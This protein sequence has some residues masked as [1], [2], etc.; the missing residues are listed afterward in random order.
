MRGKGQMSVLTH[1]KLIKIG[2]AWLFRNHPI[3]IT[4][5]GTMGEE[6]DVIGFRSGDST[7]I[8]CKASRADYYADKEK[9]FRKYPK[10]GMGEHRYF[11][12]PVGLI[13]HLVLPDGWGLLETDGRRVYK[14]KQANAQSANERQEKVILLSALRRIARGVDRSCSINAYVYNTQNRATLTI[15]IDDDTIELTGEESE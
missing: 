2:R 10:S 3:V 1:Q 9:W 8:E 14:R 7:L 4:E 6:P 12:T 13:S 11:L 15:D 5:I